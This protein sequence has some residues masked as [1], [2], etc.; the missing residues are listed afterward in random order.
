M[1]RR[2]LLAP[3]ALLVL[4]AA[5]A[6]A[7]RS[8]A[9]SVHLIVENRKPEM[10]TIYAMRHSMRYRLGMVQGLQTTRLVIR[11]HMIGP[12]GEVQLA[13]DPLG[14]PNQR[15]TRTIYV[16]PGDTLSLELIY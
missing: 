6:S 7:P 9:D 1:V 13:V 10:V 2:A 12:G 11:P 3:L 5:C 14:N 15:F 4:I 8:E 16:Q